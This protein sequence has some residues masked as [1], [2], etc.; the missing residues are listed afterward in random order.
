MTLSEIS[1]LRLY[2]QRIIQTE[3][4]SAK[5][6]VSWMGAMQAQDYAMAKLAAGLR[7]QNATA[8]T[9]ENALNKGDIIRTHLLRPTWH[10]VSKD[11]IYWM[12]ALTA[13][14]IKP[15]LR[16]RHKDLELTDAVFS[17]ANKIIEKSLLGKSLSREEIA[18]EFNNANIKT[19]N[20][21]LS[22]LLLNAELNAL[23][24]SAPLKAKKQTYALLKERV[25]K[26]NMLSRDE[27]LAV[28]A[29]RYFRSHAPATVYDFS[30]WSGLTLKDARLALS[31][32][33][34]DFVSAIIDSKEYWFTDAFNNIKHNDTKIHLLPAYDEFLISYKDRSASLTL[35]DNK[36]AISDNGIFR[37]LILINGEVAGLWKSI[38]KNG[39]LNISI[40]FFQPQ[41]ASV[42][43]KT[44]ELAKR[45]VAFYGN[46][47]LLLEKL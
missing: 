24:C 34:E 42:I 40:D 5:E 47:T 29:G 1:S 23:I 33:K 28:L 11:D 6:I 13:P 21:R 39:N 4:S 20:N 8:D 36:K 37:P 18:K 15:L 30:W 7:L 25:P 45:I 44:N 35:T 43:K 46:K 32:V 12:L 26:Q 16:S 38:S 19:D 22:H 27:A 31:F 9:I 10:F 17:K 3:F 41:Q 14:Q 2:N